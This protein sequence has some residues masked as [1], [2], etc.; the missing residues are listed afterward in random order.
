MKRFVFD[1][2]MIPILLL[3]AIL[4]RFKRKKIHI[5]IGPEP[6]I[7][8]VYHKKALILFGYTCET[9]VVSTYFI[10]QSFDVDFSKK[11]PKYLHRFSWYIIFA[12]AVLRYRCLYI[13]FNGGPLYGTSS[14]LR[15]LEPYLLKISGTK[16]VVMPY[17]GDVM[18]CSSNKNLIFKYGLIS[19]YPEYSK[20][21]RKIKSQVA[22]WTHFSDF[23]FSGCDWVDYTYY[24]DKLML[25]HFSID[26]DIWKPILNISRCETFKILHAPNHRLIKGT[27][28]LIKAVEK[29]KADGKDIELILVEKRPNNEVR[30]LINSVDLVVDQLIIGWYAMFALEGMSSGKPVVCYIRDD[31]K[32]LYE[33]SNVLKDPLPLI[34]ATP[35]TIYEKLC[36][37]YQQREMLDNIGRDSRNFVI[38][39]HSI[40]VIGKFFHEAN[41][42]I[43][44]RNEVKC[45][46]NI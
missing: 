23:I 10:T 8:N 28:S 43:G 22:R 27:E 19:H 36:E 12:F 38:K 3:I 39:Y 30:E 17:G 16:V 18:D 13:Y 4:S 45:E 21:I 11:L 24:W 41:V 33:Y 1:C 35:E 26:T 20:N 42:K 7:N 29:M 5:G 34:S 46:T 32:K 15:S 2:I 25:A 44:L 31:L 37:V 6:L 9:F 40:E 14:F